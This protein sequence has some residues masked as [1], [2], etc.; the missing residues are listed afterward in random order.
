MGLVHDRRSNPSGPSAALMRRWRSPAA[1]LAAVS[2]S[3]LVAREQPA[4]RSDAGDVELRGPLLLQPLRWPRSARASRKRSGCRNGLV[5]LL[6]TAVGLAVVVFH[7]RPPAR[8]PSA[9]RCR[10]WG[11]HQHL[12]LGVHAPQ[13]RDHTQGLEGLARSN[14]V[15]EQGHP[16]AGQ[17][18][19]K[20]GYALGLPRGHALT[21]PI[22]PAGMPCSK[23]DPLRDL[24]RSQSAHSLDMLPPL[25]D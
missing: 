22:G 4:Q 21:R 1:R 17:A 20:I 10:G 16:V 8:F 3:L 19:P 24:L 23:I 11:H 7:K 15:G 2:V 18:V 25:S 6:H 5:A 12:G 13:Q 9:G 14:L